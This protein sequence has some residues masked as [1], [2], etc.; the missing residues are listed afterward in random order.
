[1]QRSFGPFAPGK[2]ATQYRSRVPNNAIFFAVSDAVFDKSL[3]GQLGS[4][5]AWCLGEKSG[6]LGS[7]RASKSTN[8]VAI[9]PLQLEDGLSSCSWGETFTTAQGMTYPH[10]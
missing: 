8:R 2:I 3:K 5:A 4:R 7:Q 9:R 1:L 10:H 6:T